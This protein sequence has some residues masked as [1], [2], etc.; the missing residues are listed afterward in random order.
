MKIAREK[1]EKLG[2]AKIE[3]CTHCSKASTK[4]SA[5]KCFT[6]ISGI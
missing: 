1:R 2:K 3:V 4:N 6:I 5:K